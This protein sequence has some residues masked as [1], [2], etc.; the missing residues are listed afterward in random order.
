MTRLLRC[1]EERRAGDPV[2]ANLGS[3]FSA[4]DY[5]PE[6]LRNREHGT[7]AFRLTI[8]ADGLV[9]DC[10]VTSSSRSAA[11]DEATCR[12]LRERARYRPARDAAGNPTTGS[13]EGS[14]TWTLPRR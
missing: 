13:D 9:S 12:L 6:A 5:P 11:L 14:V 8:G 4:D 7:V 1:A 3:Y 10:T 2:R